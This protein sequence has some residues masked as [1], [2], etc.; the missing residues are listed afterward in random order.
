[1][2]LV[3]AGGV[4]A[5]RFLS[6]L[7]QVVPA[8]EVVTVVNTGDDTELHGLSISPDIDTVTYTLADA[9][10]RIKGWGLREETWHAMEALE[11]FDDVRP[12][13]SKAAP[14]WFNLGDR[15]LATHFYRTAR[16]KEGATLAE[17]TDEIRRAFDV[18]V[19]IVPMTNDQVRTVVHCGTGT[20]EFQEYFVKLRHDVAITGVDFVGA[21]EAN[22]IDP[23]IVEQASSIVIA[24][25]NPIVSI[26]P[27]RAIGGVDESL[28][29]HRGK[30]TAISP[31]VAGAALKGPADRMLVELGIEPSVVGVARIYK[32]VCSTLIIDEQD[33]HLAS[34]VESE[35]LRCVV[36]DTMMSRPGVAAELARIAISD[37]EQEGDR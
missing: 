14:R 20:I 6:G 10:D 24:P 1:M 19:R 29:R 36:T 11:R 23:S 32:D 16:L 5:A 25:S 31:I 15:D 21:N 18:G 9:I 26:G 8:E 27:M 12:P 28:R 13:G 33:R 37:N 35:G 17:V 3:L 4:G 30:V 22:F 34:A 7:I 2:I